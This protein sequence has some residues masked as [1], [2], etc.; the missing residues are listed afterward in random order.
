M[1]VDRLRLFLGLPHVLSNGLMVY[2]PTMQ[3]IGVLSEGV[4][5]VMF[6]LATFNKNKLLSYSNLPLS[7]SD[8]DDYEFL[9]ASPFQEN[10]AEAIKFFVREDV[11]F[12]NG[13][14]LLPMQ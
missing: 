10:I 1:N 12:K 6:D 5:S 7:D 11:H 8:E 3:Q 4:F 2:S 13:C 9:I 14:F